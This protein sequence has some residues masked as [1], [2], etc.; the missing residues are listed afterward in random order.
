MNLV[1]LLILPAVI[2]LRDNNPARWTIA[3]AALVV[4]LVAIGFS[5][6]KVGGFAE[7]ADVVEGAAPEPEPAGTTTPR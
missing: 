5:K 3:G 4:V 7:E 6:R 1:S 2:S